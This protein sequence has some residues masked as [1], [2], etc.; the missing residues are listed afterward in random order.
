[1]KTCHQC[2]APLGEGALF[3]AA[4]G[5][6]VPAEEKKSRFC[7]KCG[8]KLSENA[9]F[10]HKCG[11]AAPA[12]KA[13]APEPV[14]EPAAE[15]VKTDE[16]W[17]D[18]FAAVESQVAKQD[19]P[20]QDAPAPAEKKPA[21]KK[22]FPVLAVC[23]AAA[24]VLILV[25]GLLLGLRVYKRVQELKGGLSS[26][27]AYMESGDYAS[28]EEAYES[29][30]EN[31][32]GNV[33]VSIGLAEALLRQGRLGEAMSLL[34]GLE[35]EEKDEFYGTY[36]NLLAAAQMDPYISNL[37]LDDFPIVKLTLA[38]GTIGPEMGDLTVLEN[39]S[40]C[41]IVE[42]S[43]DYDRNEIHI[44]YQT[45]EPSYGEEN[46]DITVKL[47]CGAYELSCSRS[48]LTP[49]FQEADLRLVST[50]VSQYPTVRAY[51]RVADAESGEAVDGEAEEPAKA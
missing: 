40:S 29:A 9:A 17:A 44:V 39:G 49:V 46:R 21:E 47:D 30:L 50:D 20:Q 26:G 15:P 43:V 42:S 32:S 34:Q 7:H 22:K 2:G 25:V 23:L 1:M 37:N 38:C 27:A 33:E 24:G 35:I 16:D 14:A 31:N 48:Y 51:F 3:C 19:V 41:G 12:E 28:A 13:P 6:A 45:Y 10:C 5:A 8:A 4:C 18:M 11:T 36:L